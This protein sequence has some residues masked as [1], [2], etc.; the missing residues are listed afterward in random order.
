MYCSISEIETR[1]MNRRWFKARYRRQI[2]MWKVGAVRNAKPGYLRMIRKLRRNSCFDIL[3]PSEF[4][5]TKSRI[6][7]KWRASLMFHFVQLEIVVR[8]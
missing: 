3:L 2:R 1:R 5:P 6:H 7:R 8:E 4:F